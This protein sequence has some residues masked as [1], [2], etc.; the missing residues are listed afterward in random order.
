[1][2]IY[3]IL[4]HM[5][6]KR[7]LKIIVA[8]C[9]VV[10]GIAFRTIWHPGNNIEFVTT[11]AFL[12]GAYLGWKWSI[13]VP[14]TIM[15]VTDSIIGNTNIFVFTWSAYIIIGVM[16]YWGLRSTKIKIIQA[17]G[18]GVVAGLW[19]YLWT[20][21]G[22]WLLDSWGMYPKTLVGLADAY[23]YGLPFLKFNVLGN[24]LFVPSSFFIVEKAKSFHFGFLK[25]LAI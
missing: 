10:L 7:T 25:K 3:Q 11:A 17:T 16:G 6:R 14:L 21:F 15:V 1:M 4:N 2:E 24:L 19:F 18:L 13:A 9:L 22:V 8:L 23:L 5:E 12:A 20:N